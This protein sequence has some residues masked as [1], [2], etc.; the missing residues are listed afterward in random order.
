MLKD[1]GLSLSL[2][3][4]G[5]NINVSIINNKINNNKSIIILLKIINNML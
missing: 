1:L 5:I 3:T 4:F 2:N